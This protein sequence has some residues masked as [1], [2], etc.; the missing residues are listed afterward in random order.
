MTHA[1]LM[2]C[3]R[4]V[5]KKRLDVFK[6]INTCRPPFFLYY[7]HSGE[8]CFFN[9]FGRRFFCS[10]HSEFLF[11]WSTTETLTQCQTCPQSIKKSEL[12]F[13]QI[14]PKLPYGQQGPAGSWGKDTVRRVHFGV[15]LMSYFAPTTLSSD[16]KVI[17][18]RY[19]HIFVTDRGVQYTVYSRQTD[20]PDQKW[21]FFVTHR[22]TIHHWDCLR[23][24]SFFVPNTNFLSLKGD[25]NWP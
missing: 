5:G 15:F 17:I 13:F 20:K 3:Y 7:I 4:G 22:H 21:W 23:K 8:I 1:M 14:R 16:W 19:R 9:R 2:Q 10:E 12:F 25:P 11:S 18:F 6:M 24:C